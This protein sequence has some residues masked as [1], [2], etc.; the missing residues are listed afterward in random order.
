MQIYCKNWNQV[1]KEQITGIKINQK[2]LIDPSFHG[3]N[4]LFAFSIENNNGLPSYMKYYV[5]QAE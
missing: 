4:R 1:L 3:V 5:P 2:Y